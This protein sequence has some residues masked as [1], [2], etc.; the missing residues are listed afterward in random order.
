MQSS[1][2]PVTQ[3]SDIDKRMNTTI[4]KLAPFKTFKGLTPSSK[5]MKMTKA[6]LEEGQLKKNSHP[7]S[8]RSYLGRIDTAVAGPSDPNFS[9]NGRPKKQ[10]KP[11]KDDKENPKRQS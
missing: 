2:K 5:T 10:S 8:K 7:Q 6:R 3:Q 9:K 11:D 4:T 1:Q